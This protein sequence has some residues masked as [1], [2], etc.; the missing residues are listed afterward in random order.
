MNHRSTFLALAFIIL[1]VLLILPLLG[2]WRY[3]TGGVPRLGLAD[4]FLVLLIVPLFAAA[5]LATRRII[6]RR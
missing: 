1:A 5:V 6:R 3:D 4:G 2:L